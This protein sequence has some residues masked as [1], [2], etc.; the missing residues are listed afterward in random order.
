MS[1]NEDA[2]FR[3]CRHT[4]GNLILLQALPR[5]RGWLWKSCVTNTDVAVLPA[6]AEN[7]VYP[8]VSA[9]QTL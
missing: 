7:T 4:A 2:A 6:G 1:K 9:E 8:Q 3:G 5:T